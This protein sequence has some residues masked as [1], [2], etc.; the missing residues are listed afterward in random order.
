MLL[1]LYKVSHGGV[2]WASRCACITSSPAVAQVVPVKTATTERHPRTKNPRADKARQSLQTDSSTRGKLLSQT[3]A[4]D[5][6]AEPP[7]CRLA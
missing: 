5:G 1:L 4:E 6:Y 2:P 7:A 3:N